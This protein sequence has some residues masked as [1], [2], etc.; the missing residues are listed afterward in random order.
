MPVVAGY[1]LRQIFVGSIR[2]GSH[3][4]RS[5][6]RRSWHYVAV[7]AGGIFACLWWQGTDAARYLWALLGQ[8]LIP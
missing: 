2:A 7:L 8:V 6:Q 5:G 3:S 1:R 4:V